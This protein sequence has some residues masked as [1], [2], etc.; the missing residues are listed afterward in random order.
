MYLTVNTK[1]QSFINEEAISPNRSTD[2]GGRAPFFLSDKHQAEA[3]SIKPKHQASSI[4]KRRASSDKRQ[5]LSVKRQASSIK[6]Q[7]SSQ[8]SVKQQ[9]LNMV[10]VIEGHARRFPVVGQQTVDRGAL[11]K[12]Y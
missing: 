5:A 9:A 11:I 8:R 4:E 3:P 2:R 7:A 10:P 6:R 1:I 12:F